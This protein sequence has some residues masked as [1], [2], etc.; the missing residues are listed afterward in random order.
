MSVE[1]GE[2]GNLLVGKLRGVLAKADFDEWIRRALD[3]IQRHKKIRMLILLE[4]FAGWE[5]GVDWGDVSFAFDHDQDVERIAIVGDER[6]KEEAFVFTAAP[7]RTTQ[8]EF[9]P[10]PRLE[11]ARAWLKG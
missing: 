4:D 11:A 6:W 7:F 8:I 9:F 5:R 1:I 3:S 2:E 10:R